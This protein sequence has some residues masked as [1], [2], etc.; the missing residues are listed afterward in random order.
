MKIY[1][2]AG[3]QGETGL[4]GGDRIR[5]SDLRMDVIGTID[6]LNAAFGV[7]RWLTASSSLE[8]T[9]NWLQN[10]LFDL[11]SELA[12][13]P[14]GK[15]ELTSVEDSDIER[16][17]LEIDKMTDQL[18]ELKNFILPGGSPLAAQLHVARAVC[19]RLERVLVELSADSFVRNEPLRFVNR[20]SDWIFCS[21]RFANFESGVTDIPWNKREK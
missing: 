12:C 8:P 10:A 11:G 9:L 5:K 1:T 16:L 20:L 14:G 21:C 13:P 7:C 6:E 2:K 15:F 18:P 19:R 3:D 4:L 17:E